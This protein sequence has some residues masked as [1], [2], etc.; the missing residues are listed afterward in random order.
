MKH[1][2]TFLSPTELSLPSATHKC[3]QHPVILIL[4]AYLLPRNQNQSVYVNS[5]TGTF[6]ARVFWSLK[7]TCKKSVR[8]TGLL[9]EFEN[10]QSPTGT[11]PRRPSVLMRTSG[12]A[13]LLGLGVSFPLGHGYLSVV[14]EVCSS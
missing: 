3:H 5:T 2:T 7:D 6:M 14:G 12:T 9:A 11:N 13:G 1:E 4:P 8:I 10:R